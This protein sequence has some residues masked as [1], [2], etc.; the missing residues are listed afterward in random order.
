MLGTPPWHGGS[1]FKLMAKVLLLR[2]HAKATG[3][4]SY[5]YSIVL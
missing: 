5:L 3:V 1:L 2:L 4:K